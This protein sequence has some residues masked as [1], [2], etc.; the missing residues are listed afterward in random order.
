M[1]II[2]FGYTHK[3]VFEQLNKQKD[4]EEGFFAFVSLNFSTKKEKKKVYLKQLTL[5]IYIC[6][7]F[8]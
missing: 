6:F 4:D 7:L 1:F 2:I 8:L 3:F 5:S